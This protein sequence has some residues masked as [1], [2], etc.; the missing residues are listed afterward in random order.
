MTALNKEE[1]DI[2]IS[3]HIPNKNI[4]IEE[5]TVKG[6]MEALSKEIEDEIALGRTT[7][8]ILNSLFKQRLFSKKDSEYLDKHLLLI[9]A[10]LLFTEEMNRAILNGKKEYVVEI[11]MNT[12]TSDYLEEIVI[13][14]DFKV[15]YFKDKMYKVLLD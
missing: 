5:Y 13:N 12:Y 6:I 14:K 15:K 7:S 1:V 2:V 9:D 8:I 11:N 10:V 4:D 3:T